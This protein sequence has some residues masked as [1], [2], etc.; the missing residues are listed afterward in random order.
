MSENLNNT[1]TTP[2]AEIEVNDA[3]VTVEK[4][5][6]KHKKTG[7]EIFSIVWHHIYL[8]VTAFI[9]IVPVLWMIS[10]AFS[11]GNTLQQVKFL[12]EFS[13]KQFEKLFSYKSDQTNKLPDFV[14]AFKN[15]LIISLLNMVLVV[16]IATLNGFAVSRF[17]FKGKKTLIL[18][19]MMLQM[20][21]S[22]MSMMAYFIIFQYFG[23]IGK[24]GGVFGLILVYATGSVPINLFIVRGY[25]RSIPKSLDEAAYIDGASKVQLFFKIIF[26][27]SFPIIGFVAVNSFMSPWLDYML[28]GKLLGSSG[29]WQTVA[30][31]LYRYNTIGENPQYEPLL[32]MAGALITAI[33]IVIVNFAMQKYIVYGM[34][35]GAEKG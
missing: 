2:V 8:L 18:T 20:F 6:H 25:L 29:D 15:T 17:K 19:M 7:K 3:V 31:W 10:A 26:P 32:F 5:I 35:T 13:F 12:K 14:N 27:L 24:F 21:P 30:V 1:N 4:K 23:W 33:P 22:F 34:A 9:I 28:Q 16:F 11:K